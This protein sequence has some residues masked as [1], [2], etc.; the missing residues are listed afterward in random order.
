MQLKSQFIFIKSEA[1]FH[2]EIQMSKKYGM[3]FSFL[4]LRAFLIRTSASSR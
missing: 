1:E 3:R 4:K 2:V